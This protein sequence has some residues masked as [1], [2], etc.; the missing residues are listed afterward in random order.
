MPKYKN[1]PCPLCPFVSK[2]LVAREAKTRTALHFLNNHT[3]QFDFVFLKHG[4][5]WERKHSG[6]MSVHNPMEGSCPHCKCYVDHNVAV[7]HL[8]YNWN[9][10]VSKLHAE[11]LGV[12]PNEVPSV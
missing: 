12:N 11:L 7:A 2:A 6:A 10:F 8:V 5:D 1:A 4:E 9:E 3:N